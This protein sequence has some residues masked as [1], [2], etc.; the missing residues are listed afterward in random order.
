MR[1]LGTRQARVS[2]YGDIGD[3]ELAARAASPDQ[4]ALVW[5]GMREVVA[6]SPESGS[7][8][9]VYKPDIVRLPSDF[10][11]TAALNLRRTNQ[12]GLPTISQRTR[13]STV[14][15]DYSERTR[16]L[17]LD[18]EQLALDNDSL[19]EWL[20]AA[21]QQMLPG[22]DNH[23]IFETSL[24]DTVCAIGRLPNGQVTMTEVPR[25]HVNAVREM[26]RPIGGDGYRSH[27]DVVIE[28]PVRTVARYFLASMPQG[29]A[30]RHHGK[31]TEVTAF[32]LVNRAGFSIGLWSPQ[33]GLFN[34]YSFLAPKELDQRTQQAGDT[35]D[36]AKDALNAY[37]R[38][39]F[40]QLFIQLTD[41]K[42][43]QLQ[44]STYAQVVWASESGLAESIKPVADEYA[45]K[46]GLEFFRIPV[47]V[48]EAMAGGL[49]LG[50]FSFGEAMPVGAAIVPQVNLAR[51]LMV[52]ADTEESERRRFEEA[53]VRKR[54]AQAVFTILA[55]PVLVAALLLGYFASL[56]REQVT[57]AIRD[58]R[59][60]SRTA[61]LKPALDRR[62]SYEANLKWYQ[63]FIRQVSGLRRQQPVGIG[64]LYQLDS[65]YPFTT[66]PTFFVS[67]LKMTPTG[68]V[69]MKGLAKNKDAIAAFLKSL[70]FAGGAESGSRLFGNL[71][72]EVQERV[73]AQTGRQAT[74]QV[75]GSTLTNTNISPGTVA[76]S[77]KGDYL[78][79]AEFVPVDPTKKP[80]TPAPAPAAKPAQ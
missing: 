20:V 21:E 61:E 23:P 80:A 31:E 54:R 25:Q 68:D 45:S 36:A 44:L 12:L 73:A 6:A 13:F 75:T 56:V 18:G 24:E 39:A 66:D 78:P 65:N 43:E 62:R 19:A 60:D 63:E 8:P 3:R 30:V 37:I 14:V 50:S 42:L 9:G 59:A 35:E 48:D 64:L 71:A 58:A 49:L 11:L 46:S 76:W 26:V 79:M 69:E 67:D 15:A 29:E 5:N 41:E 28:T 10:N 72:Y 17:A 52:L 70:E 16:I 1:N 22:V 40:D 38:K 57:I 32:L 55:A 4:L 7:I 33:T 47:P 53:Q 34:E 51:D 74:P 2:G 77:M 27:L